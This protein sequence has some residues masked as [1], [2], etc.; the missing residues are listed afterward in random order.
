MNNC[1]ENY[2]EA[3]NSDDDKIRYEKL[4][5][6]FSITGRYVDQ[7]IKSEIQNIDEMNLLIKNFRE[8]FKHK[9]ILL[10]PPEVHNSIFRFN[11][12]LEFE[13]SILSRGTFFGKL[14]KL[15][16]IEFIGGFTE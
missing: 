11:W 15:N 14:N 8:K 7:H 2:I 9:L 1:I 12:K 4:K 16:L 13:E 5:S 10:K 6:S 3:W